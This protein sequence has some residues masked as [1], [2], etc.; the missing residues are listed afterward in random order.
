[1]LKR[2]RT[3]AQKDQF[4]CEKSLIEDEKNANSVKAKEL[5]SQRRIGTLYSAPNGQV[6]STLT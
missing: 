6:T 4:C 3:A 2:T 5:V 1:M